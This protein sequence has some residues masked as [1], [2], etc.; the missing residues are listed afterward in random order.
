[1]IFDCD[2]VLVDSESLS[3]AVLAEMLGEQGLA[4]SVTQAR[5]SFQG[6]RLDG[7]LAEA[8]RQLGR[9]LPEGWLASYER[10]R[11]EA[12]R[13]QLKPVQ[14]AA[15]A[16][17][18]VLTAGLE[19][20]VASQ[21]KVEKTR[22]SLR[23]TGL[24][25]LFAPRALFSAH[26]V[27]HGKPSPDLFLHAAASM[28]VLPQECVVLEDSPSGVIAG[29]RAGMRVLGLTADSDM[30]ALKAAG[31]ETIGSLRELPAVLGIG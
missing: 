20:C 11:T 5:A 31:A 4:M 27:R 30:A 1:M 6:L 22:L 8:Q 17:K 25:E 23:L 16:V 2:G 3:N 28:D 12:F 29:V 7:V 21:G 10:R 18:T 14:G 9:R 15:E 26:A 24:D 19:V 13:R